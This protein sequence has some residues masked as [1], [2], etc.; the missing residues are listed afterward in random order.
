MAAARRAL[1]AEELH[2]SRR[3]VFG[4][5]VIEMQAAASAKK[6]DEKAGAA[7]VAA[8]AGRAAAAAEAFRQVAATREQFRLEE[9]AE[10]AGYDRRLGPG[11]SPAAYERDRR[12]LAGR[13]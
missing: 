10:L 12:H 2:E 5:A 13:G 9:Q 1:E 11:H 8:A 6:R 7:R 3:N 4:L